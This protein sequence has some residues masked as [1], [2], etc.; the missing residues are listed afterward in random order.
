MEKT[1]LK[2][3]LV[4]ISVV[5]TVR[6]DQLILWKENVDILPMGND[7]WPTGNSTV[8]KEMKC[9]T[10]GTGNE[11]RVEIVCSDSSGYSSVIRTKK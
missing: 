1:H 6:N 11:P 4:F 7:N 8:A 3:H 9:Y 5:G 10:A 2:N